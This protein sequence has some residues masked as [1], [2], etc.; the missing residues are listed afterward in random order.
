MMNLFYGFIS[1]IAIQRL[2]EV[3][4][5]KNNEKWMKAQG[6][7][8]F[9]QDH[10]RLIVSMHVLFFVGLFVEVTLLNKSLSKLWPFLVMF[11]L[12]AQAGRIWTL[13][14][15][16]RFWNTKIIVLPDAN[17]IQQGPYRFIKHPNY[18]IVCTELFVIPLMFNAYFTAVIFS[19]LNLGMM[20][21]RI[22]IEERALAQLTNY[23]PSFWGRTE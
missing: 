19:L 15:L 11:F 3:G 4:L 22:P 6:A 23:K 8:E 13:T 5:A 9:G 14:T 16:G 7:V 20:S 12:A 18:C 1:I 2:L 17:P 10:Y 21:I